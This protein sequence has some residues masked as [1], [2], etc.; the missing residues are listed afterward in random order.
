MSENIPDSSL[1]ILLMGRTGNG[2]SSTGNAI[3]MKKAFTANANVQSLT[4]EAC[5]D[6]S[7][8]KGRALKVVD[9]PG[10]GDNRI[11]KVADVKQL[12]EAVKFAI[13]GNP[14]G[15]HAILYVIKYGGRYS[16]EDVETLKHLKKIMG[17]DFI[18]NHGILVLTCGDSFESDPEV[19]RDNLSFEDWVDQQVEP[20]FQELIKEC[21]KRVILFDNRAENREKQERQVANLITM[22]DKLSKNGLRYT[23][24]EFQQAEKERERLIRKLGRPYLKDEYMKELA[25]ITSCFSKMGSTNDDEDLENLQKLSL[26]AQ[27]LHLK[28]VAV[29]KNTDALKSAITTVI[30]TKATI[31]SEI[32]KK[33]FQCVQVKQQAEEK[34]KIEE[35]AL[36]L[37]KER[38]EFE[39][40]KKLEN[41]RIMR[42]KEEE[43]MIARKKLEEKEEEERKRM[44]EEEEKLKQKEEEMRQQEI[45][46]LQDMVTAAE[47]S[48][49]RAEAME[50]EYQELKKSSSQG[51]ISTV[52]N[53][54]SN[55]A[56]VKAITSW[57]W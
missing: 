12:V 27:E 26:R 53:F 17:N 42:L 21:K 36:K 34:R 46:R 40:Q 39:A 56:P 19:K 29:D 22:I 4:V 23:N 54:V 2:K 43:A 16:K 48:K 37:E 30:N 47:E 57:F 20:N 9:S 45:K 51:I 31:D 11:D 14:N 24:K 28:I 6:F 25:L 3:L 52:A 38:A 15:Y 32:A 50:R 35:E 1:D 49:K 44:K 41:E 5:L 33:S 7:E 10:L 8:F 13:A 18:R 55:L